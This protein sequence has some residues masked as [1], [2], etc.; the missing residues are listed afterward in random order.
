MSGVHINAK[1]CYD[2]KVYEAKYKLEDKNLFIESVKDN[3]TETTELSKRAKKRANKKRNRSEKQMLNT[4]KIENGLNTYIR[5]QMEYTH[6]IDLLRLAQ[7]AEAI[8]LAE[9][10]ENLRTI[11]VPPLQFSLTKGDSSCDIGNS[12][13]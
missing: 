12:N 13:Y 10:L 9:C 3:F 2:Q 11:A 1:V 5:K 4:L 7:N 6:A 8:E